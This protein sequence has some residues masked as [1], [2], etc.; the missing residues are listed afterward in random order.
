[1]DVTPY[2][3]EWHPGAP[4]DDLERIFLVDGRGHGLM[5]AIWREVPRGARR[6]LET[7]GIAADG[8]RRGSLYGPEAA[9]SQIKRWADL[10][11]TDDQ[12]A[13]ELREPAAPACAHDW[14][15]DGM[16]NTRRCLS[17]GRVDAYSFDPDRGLWA[18]RE[19]EAPKK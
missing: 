16:D 8:R 11:L 12:L 4:P 15:L 18:W 9:A 13:E 17:C 6:I 1:M 7:V 5:L 14:A 10:P 2:K 3:F 19:L